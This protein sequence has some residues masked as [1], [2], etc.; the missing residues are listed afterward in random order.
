MAYID[1]EKVP[2]KVTET[3]LVFLK[4]RSPSPF[5][6]FCC[7]PLT[8]AIYLGRERVRIGIITGYNIQHGLFLCPQDLL[9]R[10]DTRGIE[11]QKMFIRYIRRYP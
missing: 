10:A 11:H 2:K 5:L 7:Y 9:F 3:F 1:T 6:I 4:K 8:E